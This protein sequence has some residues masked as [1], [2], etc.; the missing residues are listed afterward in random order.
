MALLHGWV[1][2]GEQWL[3]HTA[4]FLVGVPVS[5][6]LSKCLEVGRTPAEQTPA[7]LCPH[8]TRAA[9]MKTAENL[10]PRLECLPPS[11][12]LLCGVHARLKHTVMFIL[13][14]LVC[15]YLKLNIFSTYT[16][17]KNP[18]IE[19]K[20][21]WRSRNRWPEMKY[22]KNGIYGDWIAEVVTRSWAPVA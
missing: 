11:W 20:S 15:R 9:E 10:V 4:G 14:I 3:L 19:T 17:K 8:M 6:P 16:T 5:G 2:L 7:L 1:A 12:P 13:N 22:F 18:F 21:N